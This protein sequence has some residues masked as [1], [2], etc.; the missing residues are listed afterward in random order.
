VQEALAW[1]G[2]E[3]TGLSG[4]ARE[5]TEHVLSKGDLSAVDGARDLG[6]GPEAEQVHTPS[7][8]IA[9]QQSLE[10]LGNFM[11]RGSNQPTPFLWSF[12]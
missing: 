5:W 11:R 6:I 10:W 8:S 3:E 12:L 1:A 9:T 2:S 4:K 7:L